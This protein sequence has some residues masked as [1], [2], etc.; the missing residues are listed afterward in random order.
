M[1]MKTIG[2][3]KF[4]EQCLSLL[5]QVSQE[6]I[7]VTKR[8]RPIARLIPWRAPSTE[9]LGALK[10]KVAIHGDILST[11]IRWNAES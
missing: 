9:L 10:G 2:A 8:G 3:T 7:I 11:K 6:E 1:T 4:K 5:E